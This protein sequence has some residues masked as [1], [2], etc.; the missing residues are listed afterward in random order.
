MQA[1]HT[2]STHST[3][4]RT[5]ISVSHRVGR[6]DA[7]L[8]R[9]V[10]AGDSVAFALLDARHRAPLIRYAGRLLR[11]SEHDAE[12]VVQD[13]LVR[14]HAVLRAGNVPTD[15]LP[16]LYRL[17]RNRAFDEMRRKRWAETPLEADRHG[18]GECQDPALRMLGSQSMWQVVEDILALPPRQRQALVARELEGDSLEAVAT[19]LGVSVAAAQKLTTRARDGLVRARAARDADCDDIRTALLDAH[20]RGV[21][22][23]EHALRHIT[24][25]DACH[26]FRSRTAHHARRQPAAAV[27]A[28]L[29]APQPSA[30]PLATAA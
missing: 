13:V 10:S 8:A 15:L 22:P 2:D 6:S 25:C 28:L 9:R 1:T 4:P 16:W 11:R 14:A 23:T 18:D 26:A 5:A 21:R 24:G 27:V 29:P 17:T 7:Q 19:R 3:P 12:D 30:P 20:E